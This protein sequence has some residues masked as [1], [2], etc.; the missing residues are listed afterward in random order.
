MF[1]PTLKKTRIWK[2][3]LGGYA[4]VVLLALVFLG[5]LY[6][7]KS[8]PAPNVASS[9]GKIE[10]QDAPPPY[11][12]Q[13]VDFNLFWEVWNLVK[14][15]YVEQPVLDTQLFYGALAGI[16]GAV[17][18][19]YTVFLEPETTRKFTAELS[20]TFSGIGAEIGLR[21]EQLVIIAPLPDTPAQRAGLKALDAI[22]AIDDKDTSGMPIDVAV[23]H[24]R[25]PKGSKV[26]LKIFRKGWK[27]PRDIAIVREEIQVNPVRVEL[28]E[29]GIAHLKIIHF[30]EQLRGAFEEAVQKVLAKNPKGLV[31]DLRNNP[32]GFFEGA[33]EVASAW[34]ANDQVVVYQQDQS[35]K[36]QEFHSR[37]QARLKD[38]P[39]VV[40]VNEGSASA[41]EIV[42]GALQDYEI[43]KL[44]GEK[45]FG[46]GSV[47]TFEQLRGGS[48]VKIT[49]A[50]WLTPKGRVINKEGIAPDLEVKMGKEEVDN[51]DDPQLQKAVELLSGISN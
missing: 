43:A 9:G 38:I 34:L 1:Y 8:W 19:P 46:K 13:N 12:L 42:A 33:I 14:D 40:L 50:Q 26:T 10:N 39:T 28:R 29:D 47:Q 32:G 22:L 44:I 49:V 36:K 3:F 15:K 45:T 16:A 51:G 17:G 27:E 23:S 18:D 35:G 5:G 20:G 37:G 2:R 25:G 4:V 48:A 11:L 7:G 31:L 21:K 41:S 30:N 6:V 24:I